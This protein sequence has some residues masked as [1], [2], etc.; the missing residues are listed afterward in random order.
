MA[1]VRLQCL[2][3]SISWRVDRSAALWPIVLESSNALSQSIK[4]T[5]AYRNDLQC[6][7]G[8][9]TASNE[10][11]AMFSISRRHKSSRLLAR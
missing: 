7:I 2:S 6:T 1:F 8:P 3:E 10:S 4:I 5:S 9:V 11:V